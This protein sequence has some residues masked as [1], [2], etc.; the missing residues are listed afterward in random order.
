MSNL[1]RCRPLKSMTEN[2]KKKKNC[3]EN[4]KKN[5]KQ[6][7]SPLRAPVSLLVC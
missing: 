3:E 2:E 4:E 1:R 6:V 5:L 7:I